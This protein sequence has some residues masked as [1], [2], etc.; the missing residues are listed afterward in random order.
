[1]DFLFPF[2]L[3]LSTFQLQLSAMPLTGPKLQLTVMLLSL[4][5]WGPQLQLQRVGSSTPRLYMVQVLLPH[6]HQQLAV[7]SMWLLP[8]S[9][10][11]PDC[12]H[13]GISN[14]SSI[15]FTSSPCEYHSEPQPLRRRDGGQQ[16]RR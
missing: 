10:A 7:P 13:H 15:C 14:S 6:E 3:P 2:Q 16:L 12:S 1:M 8:R 5:D 11:V 9:A 4:D